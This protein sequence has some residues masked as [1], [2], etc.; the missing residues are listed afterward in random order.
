MMPTLPHFLIL[1]YKN[2]MYEHVHT[3]IIVHTVT[4]ITK[5]LL[6]TLRVCP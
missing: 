5:V 3:A 6:G 1:D 4:I 2:M